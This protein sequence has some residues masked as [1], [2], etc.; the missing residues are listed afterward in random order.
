MSTRR[1]DRLVGAAARAPRL[2]TKAIAVLKERPHLNHSLR[3]LPLTFPVVPVSS[4]KTATR[5]VYR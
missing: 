1:R 3:L 5:P 4:L 2:L